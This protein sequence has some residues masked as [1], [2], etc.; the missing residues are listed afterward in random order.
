V[1]ETAVVQDSK[2]SPRAGVVTRAYASLAALCRTGGSDHS[3]EVSEVRTL[4]R[5][6]LEAAAAS[7]GSPALRQLV[8]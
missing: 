2:D 7:P 4:S 3:F 1:A 5:S 6:E 8:A